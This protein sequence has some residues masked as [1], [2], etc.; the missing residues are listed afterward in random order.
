MSK[1]YIGFLWVQLTAQIIYKV[2]NTEG[3]ILRSANCGTQEGDAKENGAQG[4]TRTRKELP[5][6]DFKS[7]VYTIPPPGQ[8]HEIVLKRGGLFN[9]HKSG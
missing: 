7:L 4:G 5:P 6:R 1:T 3:E 2:H 8:C 9:A